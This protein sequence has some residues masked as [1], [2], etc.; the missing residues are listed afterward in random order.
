MTR[1]L[2]KYGFHLSDQLS[3]LFPEVEDGGSNLN[4]EDD[5]KI[6]ELPIPEVIESLYETDKGE[7]PK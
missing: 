2:E 6:N 4:Q 7:V 5:Q 1:D 3:Q